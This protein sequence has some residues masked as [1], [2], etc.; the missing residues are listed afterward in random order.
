MKTRFKVT[1]LKYLRLLLTSHRRQ[2]TVGSENK[3]PAH[4]REK[5]AFCVTQTQE[6]MWCRIP[7]RQLWKTFFFVLFAQLQGDFVNIPQI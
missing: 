1:G 7:E 3:T 4:P 5:N 6:F 2:N